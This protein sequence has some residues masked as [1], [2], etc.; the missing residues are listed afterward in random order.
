VVRGSILAVDDEEDVLELVRYNF[1]KEGF[2]V[3]TATTGE[4][5]LKKARANPPR[6]ILLDIMLP[7]IDGVEICKQLKADSKTSSIPI[8]MLTAR[9]GMSGP[10]SLVINSAIADSSPCSSIVTPFVSL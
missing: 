2:K 4:D 1:H 6:I 8:I 3:E 5:A 9:G 10:L 7:G